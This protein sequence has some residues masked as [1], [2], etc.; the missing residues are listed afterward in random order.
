[1]ENCPFA[2]LAEAKPEPHSMAAAPDIR[3]AVGKCG[4]SR[5]PRLQQK[6]VCVWC[7]KYE[8]WR[9]VPTHVLETC[10]PQYAN[11]GVGRQSFHS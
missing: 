1:M 7:K 2:P 6:F 5:I 8:E 3:W 10:T 4:V 11:S 9:N